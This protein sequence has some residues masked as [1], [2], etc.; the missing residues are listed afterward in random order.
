MSVVRLNKGERDNI[1]A[2]EIDRLDALLIIKA[3]SDNEK[4]VRIAT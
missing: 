4:L 1:E 2:K 3:Y